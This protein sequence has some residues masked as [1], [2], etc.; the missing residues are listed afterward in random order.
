MTIA[1]QSLGDSDPRLLY[2]GGAGD[3]QR[4]AHHLTIPSDVHVNHPRSSPSGHHSSIG[5][6]TSRTWPVFMCMEPIL[7]LLCGPR[8][9]I[10]ILLRMACMAERTTRPSLASV[11]FSSDMGPPY[12]T[13]RLSMHS[14]TSDSGRFQSSSGILCD[15]RGRVVDDMGVFFLT[16]SLATGFLMML[17]FVVDDLG[18]AFV[19]SRGCSGEGARDTTVNERFAMF[20][21][22][23]EEE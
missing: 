23:K 6:S 2:G 13:R 21:C 19:L 5:S 17:V 12:F 4:V 10:V 8:Y 14:M 22:R 16:I 7:N 11:R 18:F 9:P 3:G 15:E 20:D 1:Y